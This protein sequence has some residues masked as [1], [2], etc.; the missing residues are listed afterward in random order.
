MVRAA[1]KNHDSV[2][3]LTN[4]NQY[5]KFLIALK[6]GSV[7]KEFRKELALEAFEHTASYD[8]TI[9]RWMKTQIKNK[10]SSWLEAMP[11]KQTLRYGENPHQKASWY[12]PVDK[13]WG[14]ANQL[15]GKEL[16]TNNLLDLEAALST[17]REFLSLIHI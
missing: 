2:T 6:E 7:T 12:G 11:L 15:Q 1:A 9:S 14:G 17:V 4:P 8:M 3:I 13:G 5:E 16:S 10:P